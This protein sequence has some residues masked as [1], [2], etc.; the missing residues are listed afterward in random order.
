MSMLNLKGRSQRRAA[1]AGYIRT[2]FRLKLRIYEIFSLTGTLEPITFF[3][4]R[5]RFLFF[6]VS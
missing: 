5:L 2:S 6:L 4:L 1:V 3:F